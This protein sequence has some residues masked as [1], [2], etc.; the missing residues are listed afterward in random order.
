MLQWPDERGS[1]LCPRC[2]ILTAPLK[3]LCQT[4]ADNSRIVCLFVE[5]A[6]GFPCNAW[7][8]KC[9]HC[10]SA[11][12][13]PTMCTRVSPRRPLVYPRIT[14]TEKRLADWRLSL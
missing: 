10:P 4:I 6:V 2:M 12:G 7:I 5:V 13:Q 3:C 1:G 11:E 8:V 9:R 14:Q